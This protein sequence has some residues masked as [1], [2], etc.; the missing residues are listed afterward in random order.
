ML[1]DI[2]DTWAFKKLLLQ[3]YC[4]NVPVPLVIEDVKDSVGVGVSLVFVR[5]LVGET[6]EKDCCVEVPSRL[7]EIKIYKDLYNSSYISKYYDQNHVMQ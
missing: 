4:L 1:E 7:L 5:L 6:D 3:G 2:L